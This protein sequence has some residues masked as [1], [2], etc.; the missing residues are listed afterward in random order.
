MFP[1]QS[2]RHETYWSSASQ[3]IPPCTLSWPRLTARLLIITKYLTTDSIHNVFQQGQMASRIPKHGRLAVIN[4]DLDVLGCLPSCDNYSLNTL[5]EKE[6]NTEGFVPT[7]NL[8]FDPRSSF[9]NRVW[10]RWVFPS[11]CD[12]L[13]VAVWRR[14]KYGLSPGLI[15]VRT[16]IFWPDDNPSK[17]RNLFWFYV[18]LSRRTT[19]SLVGSQS[20][21]QNNML[22]HRMLYFRA[23][24]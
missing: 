9:I 8:S 10:R 12:R 19:C 21:R 3:F 20:C 14:A 13:E 17:K 6:T 5:D 24:P 23:I 2:N 22:G 16:A 15:V 7:F 11:R 18:I 1:L 4:M